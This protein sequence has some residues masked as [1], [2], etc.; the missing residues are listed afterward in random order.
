MKEI[1]Y[2]YIDYKSEM[3]KQV[4]NLRYSILFEPYSKIKKYE[5]D[6]LDELSL[7]LVACDEDRV[8][9]YSRMT[10]IN[11]EGKITNV[12][13]NPEYINRRIGFEMMN[14]HIINAN[15][16]NI[17][18]LYL[19]ARIETIEFYKKVG[20]ECKDKIIISEKSGLQLQK[21]HTFIKSAHL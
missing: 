15:K 20:F 7:H 11:G 5:F 6:E 8:V 9:G 21:M 4:I 1:I 14:K 18:S 17:N 16:N 2:K 13:V 12:V 10:H 19:N 3:F